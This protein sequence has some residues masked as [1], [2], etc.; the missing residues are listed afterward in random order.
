M[1][2]DALR[3][4]GE[5]P[6]DITKK[7]GKAEAK[8]LT[9][10]D[11]GKAKPETRRVRLRLDVPGW[12]RAETIHAASAEDT[13][14]SQLAAFL[15]AYSLALYEDGDRELLDQLQAAKSL[16][17]SLRWGH[18]LDVADLAQRILEC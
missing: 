1:P 3:Q 9:V 5:A 18:D 15:L 11:S 10:A 7:W 17:Q 12:L 16:S 2:D 4:N 13:S 8:P 14:I 6:E